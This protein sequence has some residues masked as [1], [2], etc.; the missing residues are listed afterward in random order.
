M[1]SR[2]KE[3]IYTCVGILLFVFA[4][5]LY[6]VWVYYGFLPFALGAFV[7]IIFAVYAVYSSRK[8]KKNKPQT[9]GQP[10]FSAMK[11]A[12]PELREKMMELEGFTKYT[13]ENGI[14]HW[15]P[16]SGAV[17]EWAKAEKI[18]VVMKDGALEIE[19]EKQSPKIRCSYC[20]TVYDEKLDRCPNCGASRQGNEEQVKDT[21]P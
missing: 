7:I 3:E 21:T 19:V 4:I 16:P 5:G 17:P 14:T 13:D 10:T 12:S 2:G 1:S 9:I 8:A 11:N 18:D 6:V 20:G 15:K